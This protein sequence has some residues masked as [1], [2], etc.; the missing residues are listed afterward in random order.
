M[1]ANEIKIDREFQRLIPCLTHEEEEQ[2]EKNI[3]AEGIRDKLVVWDGTLIDGHN[4][5]EIAKRHGMDD[6]EVEEKEFADRNEA[7][8][9]I[10]TNQF[11]RRNLAKIDRAALGMKME[12]VL[13]IKA[14]ENQGT[15]TDIK[16]VGE[17]A[18]KFTPVVD[19]REAV[20]AKVQMGSNTYSKAKK[21]L[22][23]SS[24]KQIEE[25][26]NGETTIHSR[27]TEIM[28]EHHKVT[29]EKKRIAQQEEKDRESMKEAKRL[30]L[31]EEAAREYR[32]AKRAERAAM[33]EKARMD[34]FLNLGQKSVFDA[35]V[36]MQ[37]ITD[38]NPYL[39]E[40]LEK[41]IKWCESKKR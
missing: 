31:S 32:D 22:E 25:I 39:N 20:A 19:V 8:L 41:M 24:P 36:A 33:E 21:V 3:L 30:A 10:I 17:F 16:H 5:L 27:F 1:K 28:D 4:R 34:L 2:L 26:R 37:K 35:Q 9:W 38:D 15:R 13:K 7:I 11:G 29:E 6:L 23:N 12:A 14:K 18:E 40:F